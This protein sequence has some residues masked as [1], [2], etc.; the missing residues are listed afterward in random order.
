MA[1]G[2][3]WWPSG[4]RERTCEFSDL[5]RWHGNREECPRAGP[6]ARSWQHRQ[7]ASSWVT[8]GERSEH[9][10]VW[11]WLLTMSVPAFM[12]PTQS[13]LAPAGRPPEARFPYTH[14]PHQFPGAAVTK[15]HKQGD[16]NNRNVMSHGSGVCS[17][18]AGLRPA[19][20]AA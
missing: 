10:E 1:E 2:P 11:R 19:T 15:H 7:E 13:A 20:V 14:L 17:P 3:K 5:L 12:C 16:L 18:E 9:A 8:R 6:R 4:R